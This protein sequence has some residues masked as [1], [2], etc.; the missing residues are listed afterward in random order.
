MRI[1]P[2]E[3]A[4]VLAI[5]GMLSLTACVGT[6]DNPVAPDPPDPDDPPADVQAPPGEGGAVPPLPAREELR[7]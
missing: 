2:R 4:R 3:A 1:H 5:A 6:K 7:G